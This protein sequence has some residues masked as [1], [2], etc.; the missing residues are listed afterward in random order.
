MSSPLIL[1]VEDEE[2]FVEALEIGL[3]REGFRTAVATDGS[4]VSVRDA[5]G[6][7]IDAGGSEIAKP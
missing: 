4:K 2:S 5:E 7:L 6:R 1:I 3:Q